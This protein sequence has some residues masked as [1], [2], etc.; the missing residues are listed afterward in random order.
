MFKFKIKIEWLYFVKSF[1]FLIKFYIKKWAF[2]LIFIKKKNWKKNQKINRIEKQEKIIS[3]EEW[4]IE[5]WDL[6]IE[7]I[8]FYGNRKKSEI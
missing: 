3:W 7:K 4:L 5:R 1:N 6:K 8:C 2:F